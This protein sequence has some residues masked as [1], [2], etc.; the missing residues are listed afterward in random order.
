MHATC[1]RLGMNCSPGHTA[2]WMPSLTA[3]GKTGGRTPEECGE[4]VLEIEEAEAQPGTPLEDVQQVDIAVLPFLAPSDRAEDLQRRDAVPLAHLTQ[5]LVIDVHGQH[6]C[7]PSEPRLVHSS[8]TKAGDSHAERLPVVPAAV[9]SLTSGRG[10]AAAVP[11]RGCSQAAPARSA[12]ML[13][14]IGGMSCSRVRRAMSV[15]TSR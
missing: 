1:M 10:A 14:M 3:G 6:D 11:A 15:S 13:A 12:S 9:P 7:S 8:A 5:A 4:L 2:L